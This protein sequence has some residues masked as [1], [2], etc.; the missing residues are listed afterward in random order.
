MVNDNK[1]P[2]KQSSMKQITCKA[3]KLGEE[4]EEKKYYNALVNVK[5]KAA[6]LVMIL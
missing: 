5:V 4:G 3:S 1:L 6:L 2:L